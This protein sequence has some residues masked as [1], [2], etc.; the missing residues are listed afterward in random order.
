[1]SNAIDAC[2]SD[3]IE[4][5]PHRVLVSTEA[6]D[7]HAFI[8]VKDNGIGIDQETRTKLFAMFFS[9]KGA[10]GTGLGLL[11][12]HKAVTEHGGAISVE[13]EPGQGAAFTVKLPFEH[14]VASS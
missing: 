4:D 3:E 7:G 10:F 12:S 2:C 11:V 8:T 6:A 1:V 9:T 5:K 13:S 14:A